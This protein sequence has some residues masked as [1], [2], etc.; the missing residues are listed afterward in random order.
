MMY[1]NKETGIEMALPVQMEEFT[2]NALSAGVRSTLAVPKDMMAE[3]IEE[4]KANIAESH[5]REAKLHAADAAGH[6]EGRMSREANNA[7]MATEA[8]YA[9]GQKGSAQVNQV[10]N[11]AQYQ[12]A[13]PTISITKK[14]KQFRFL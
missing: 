7:R 1:G 12:A 13:L 4:T 9:S 5:A 11:V 10:Y 6:T 3:L 8:T 2:D 14:L